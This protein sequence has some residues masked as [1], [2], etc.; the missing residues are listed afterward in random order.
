MT[1]SPTTPLK[2]ELTFEMHEVRRADIRDEE[3]LEFGILGIS[4]G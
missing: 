2:Q 1:S 4:V 3:H